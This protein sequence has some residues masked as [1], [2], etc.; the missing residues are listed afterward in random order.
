MNEI[1]VVHQGR[2]GY[3]EIDGYRYG[4]ELFDGGHF[5]IAFPDGNRHSR[6]QTHL[7]SLTEFAANQDPPWTVDN[8]SRKYRARE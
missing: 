1:D 4:I 6:L 5:S 2:S 8:R 7:N 3:V